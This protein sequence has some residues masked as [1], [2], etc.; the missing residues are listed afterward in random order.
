VRACDF[1]KH[2]NPFGTVRLWTGTRLAHITQAH[3]TEHR[4]GRP[5][6]TILAA[7]GTAVTCATTGNDI[8]LRLSDPDSAELSAVLPRR[9]PGPASPPVANAPAA[10]T[11]TGTNS[12]KPTQPPKPTGS[13]RGA[14][15]QPRVSGPDAL[16]EVD[17]LGIG[18]LSEAQMRAL[19]RAHERAVRHERFWVS[20]LATVDWLDVPHLS[21]GGDPGCLVFELPST[22]DYETQVSAA[23]AF[24]VRIADAA[25]RDVGLRLP[26][27]SGLL[28]DTVPMRVP[29]LTEDFG[30]YRHAV[31]D[32]LDRVLDPG[33]YLRDLPHRYASLRE[34]TRPRIVVDLT[35][36]PDLTGAAWVLRIGD[37]GMSWRFDTSAVAMPDAHA[38][39]ESF[40]AFLQRVGQEPLTTIAL[41][42]LTP[43]VMVRRQIGRPSAYPRE[44]AADLVKA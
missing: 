4:S 8:V 15:P 41:P 37:S 13:R 44:K 32:V 10:D 22:V 39:A 26:D 3:P 27:E 12:P 17:D 40:A 21:G 36:E 23:L 31:D 28:A 29:A 20:R 14:P 43:A 18:G 30:D 9:G 11:P 42:P 1:G 33:G 35:D 7:D 6:G 24:L 2:D 38:L 16:S 5:P 34:S 19:T 25:G